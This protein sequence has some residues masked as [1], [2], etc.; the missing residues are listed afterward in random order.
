MQKGDGFWHLG[1]WPLCPFPQIRLWYA[2]ETSLRELSRL[3]TLRWYAAA[4]EPRRR[5]KN[6]FYDS[7]VDIE[8]TKARKQK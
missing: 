7:L 6:I 2:S 5:T 3:H 8:L 4:K 1:G